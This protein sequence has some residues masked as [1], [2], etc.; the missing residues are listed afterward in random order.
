MLSEAFFK[1]QRHCEELKL[2]AYM[3]TPDDVPT[4]GYGHTKGV[5]LGHVITLEQAEEY[6]K[7]D[8]HDAVEA[9]FYYLKDIEL[10][11]HQFDAII[12]M[13][14]NAGTQIFRNRDG[15]NTGIYRALKKGDHKRVM[16]EMRRWVHQAGKP[17]KGLVTRRGMEEMLYLL[18]TQ[19]GE[20]ETFIPAY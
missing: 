8:A 4:I 20:C 2:E 19:E 11:Q 6:L 13:V 17:L 1:L 18:G 14:F 5:K 9:A 10:S 16:H 15:S 12:S 3:P 7:E